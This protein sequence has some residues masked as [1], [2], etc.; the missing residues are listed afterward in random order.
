[1][2]PTLKDLRLQKQIL[3]QFQKY[4]LR[5]NLNILIGYEALL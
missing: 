1:M 2:Y 4:V 5:S 3:Q